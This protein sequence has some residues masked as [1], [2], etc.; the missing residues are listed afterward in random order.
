M[1]GM[2]LSGDVYF[3]RLDSNNNST[4]YLGPFNSTRFELNPGETEKVERTSRMRDT[5]GQVL[6]SVNLPGAA[7]VSITFDNQSSEMLAL[8]LMGTVEQLT[9]A[10]QTVTG[11][12]ITARHDRYM[13]L[14]YRNIATGSVA[15]DG[16][17]NAWASDTD[18]EEGDVI[19]DGLSDPNGP[20]WWK[21]TTAG[22]SDSS[23]PTWGTSPAAGETV[24]ESLGGVTW[25]CL[26]PVVADGDLT[27]GTDYEVNYRQGMIKIL[28]GGAIPDHTPLEIDYDT[29]S[30]AGDIVNANTVTQVYARVMLDG[31]DMVTGKP[32]NVYI[33]KI[34]MTPDNPVDLMSGE[35]V[36]TSV[37]GT[38]VTLPGGTEPYRIEWLE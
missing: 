10:G 27:E 35:Y 13:D 14:E 24:S 28:S 5:F 26:G 32:R 30:R 34:N 36:T 29:S 2:I 38:A 23:A 25:L 3:D 33:D 22:T 6:D 20:N 21:C 37:S 19:S 1:A 4:G 8:A 11:E 7:T 16:V 17:E 31:K 15:I 12:A 18:Y 9:A